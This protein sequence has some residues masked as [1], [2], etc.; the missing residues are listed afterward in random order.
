MAGSGLTEGS[1][2]VTPSGTWLNI[3]IS[4]SLLNLVW[5]GNKLLFSY[6]GMEN[7]QKSHTLRDAI[8]NYTKLKFIK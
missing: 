8:K 7:S 4:L 1:V 2:K 6:G 5:K 3:T